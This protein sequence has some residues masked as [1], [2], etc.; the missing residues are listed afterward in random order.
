[1]SSNTAIQEAAKQVKETY[2]HPSVLL[3]NA[4]IILPSTILGQK[5]SNLEK[6][7]AV[8]TFQHYRLCREF[9][10]DLI[11][12]NHG[13]VVTVASLAGY[14]TPAGMTDYCACPSFYLIDGDA[15]G[16]F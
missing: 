6:I 12:K 14:V 4:G 3:M 11:A 16:T 1:L 13:I 10:P 2:G 8:N 15:D 7:F 5:D 9:L